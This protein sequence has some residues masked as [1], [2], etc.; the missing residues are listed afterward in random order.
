MYLEHVNL[1]VADIDAMLQ[2]YRAAFPHWRIRDE[3][4]GEWYGKP[5]KWL[6]FGDDYH[7]LALSD[8]GEGNNRELAGHSVGFAHFAYVTT[9]LDGV[10]ARLNNAGYAIAKTG[11]DE[12]F[13]KNIY[14]VD[15]AG[16]EV[17][18]VEYLSDHPAER[19]LNQDR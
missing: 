1:V 7:Y 2:F 16:F 12:P 5:R 11:A 6:H 19:N 3:G 17:E 13:R 4:E 9:N 14:F 15:P 8:H 10:I 18:F